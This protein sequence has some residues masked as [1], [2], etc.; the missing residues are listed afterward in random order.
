MDTV[1][2]MFTAD[3]SVCD[4]NSRVHWNMWRQ[5]K[6]N[7]QPSSLQKQI[8]FLPYPNWAMQYIILTPLGQPSCAWAMSSDRLAACIHPSLHQSGTM[9]QPV[10]SKGHKDGMLNWQL[11]KLPSSDTRHYCSQ[12][13]IHGN[14][15]LPH[16]LQMQ[17]G[18]R[19]SKSHCFWHKNVKNK[20]QRRWQTEEPSGWR[21]MQEK[22]GCQTSTRYGAE[23]TTQGTFIDWDLSLWQKDPY[24]SIISSVV[25]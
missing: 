24:L 15:L 14:G 1:S 4:S 5:S 11:D 20:W 10:L 8:F 13:K 17:C 2:E 19:H 21:L 25:L 6:E 12:S 23:A 7:S 9:S 3:H 22:D 16:H 18:W